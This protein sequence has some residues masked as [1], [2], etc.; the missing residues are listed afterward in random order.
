MRLEH[1]AIKETWRRET[2]PVPLVEGLRR[3]TRRHWGKMDDEEILRY[4]KTLLEPGGFETKSGL[5]KEDIGLYNELRKRGLLRALGLKERKR[6]PDRRKPRRSWMAM[7]DGEL[8]SYARKAVEERAIRG[9]LELHR[10]DSGL[11][12]ELKRRGLMDEVGLDEPRRDWTSMD[13]DEILSYAL[14]LIEMEGIASQHQLMLR[15][16]GLNLIMRKRRLH[17]QI[18]FG[19]DAR[20]WSEYADNELIAHAQRLIHEGDISSKNDFRRMDDGLFQ[21]IYVRGLG[22]AVFMG[23]ERTKEREALREVVA[24]VREF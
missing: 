11:A 17:G 4:A 3:R 16:V 7:G 19:K 23:L 9:R 6:E 22:D 5:A 21:A 24:A 12:R 2:P 8:L 1:K 14:G 18:T 15:D 20:R 10:K 13:D